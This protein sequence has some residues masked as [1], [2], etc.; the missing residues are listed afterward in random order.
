MLMEGMASN[1][2]LYIFKQKIHFAHSPTLILV[3]QRKYRYRYIK[4]RYTNIKPYSVISRKKRN[5]LTF[6]LTK[7]II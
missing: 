1:H 3:L 6:I 7:V 2:H 4:V 5:L